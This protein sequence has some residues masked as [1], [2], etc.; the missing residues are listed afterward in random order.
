MPGGIVTL[1]FTDVVASTDLLDRLG[2]DGYD[3]LRRAHF[4]IL[5][6]AVAARGGTEVKN[7][8]D[9]LMVVFATP[10]RAVECAVAIQQG[11]EKHNR[12]QRDDQRMGV[13]VAL[14]AGEPIQDEADYF[15]RPVVIAKRLCDRADGGQ[16]VA[17]AVV[18]ALVADRRDL[19]FAD[20]G[21]L[22]LKGL[23]EGVPAAE[24]AW[25][26]VPERISSFGTASH[27]SPFVGRKQELARLV[28]ALELAAAGER[29][30]FLVGGE[31]GVGK[32]RLAAEFS[33][34]ALD[35]GALLLYGRC[36]PD[37]LAAYE[38]FVEAFNADGVPSFDELQTRA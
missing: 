27:Q 11:V 31:A 30:V 12:V 34:A 26:P 36:S 16:I 21:P 1:L 17:S 14:H 32:T 10:A 38:P 23:S 2:D 4:R 22:Q 6:D 18:R 5:R 33:R 13:R 19:Q 35:T 15:G 20:L 37:P 3:A 25:A 8:G 7:L 29:Q 28:D 24:V 9:G